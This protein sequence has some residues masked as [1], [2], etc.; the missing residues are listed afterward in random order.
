MCEECGCS[1]GNEVVEVGEDILKE[2]LR[3]AGHNREHL[4]E[5]GVFSVELISAPG[6]GKT[7]LIE[8]LSENLRGI[9]IAVIEGDIETERDAERIR[10]KG[11][12]A[13]QLTTGGACH[14]DA[15]LVHGALH[16]LNLDGVKL[17]FIENV[18]NL[19]CPAAFRLGAHQRW[20]IL[21]VPEG[22]D[23]PAKYPR[24]F[25]EAS[26]FI[27]NKLDLLPHFEFDPERVKREA[28]SLNPYLRCFSVS[29]RTGEGIPELAEYLMS[30]LRI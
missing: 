3:F 23:K 21:S 5:H 30:L 2:N 18:G 26:A 14:L 13:F 27:L 15:R 16:H 28:L 12:P 4:D 24:A 29:A 6:S 8:A 1:E 17:L 11:I 19:V 9:G 25:R 20:V 10:A 7:S 22:D